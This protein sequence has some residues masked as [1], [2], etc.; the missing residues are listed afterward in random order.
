MNQTNDIVPL[1]SGAVFDAL[2]AMLEPLGFALE[3]LRSRFG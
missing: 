1:A 2:C 3:H